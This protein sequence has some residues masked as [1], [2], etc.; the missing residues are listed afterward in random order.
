MDQRRRQRRPYEQYEF[1]GLED[2]LISRRKR[3][4]SSIHSDNSDIDQEHIDTALS[5][6]VQQTGVP[7]M[8]GVVFPN[9]SFP[10]DVA[11]FTQIDSFHWVLDMNVFVGEAYDQVKDI[12]IF[13]LNEFSLPP[14]KALAV[15]VQSPGSPFQYC[16]AVYSACP[17]AVLSLVWPKPGGQMQIT[18]SESPLTAKIGI[19]AEDL[20]SLP[21]LNMGQFHRIEELAM[22]VGENLFNFMQSFSGG[23]GGRLVVPLNILDQWF[24]KFQERAKKDPEYLKQFSV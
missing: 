24:K 11:S 22:K 6:R 19:A 17:S 12:C 15:Y 10:L 2:G 20:V 7:R 3:R 18:A 14:D 21:A 13:L 4:A 8:F 23:E 16:G 5:Y 1:D 9:R